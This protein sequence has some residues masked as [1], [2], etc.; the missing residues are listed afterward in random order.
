MVGEPVDMDTLTVDD[1]NLNPTKEAPAAVVVKEE[2]KPVT[3][4]NKDTPVV[5]DK[6]NGGATP[7]EQPIQQD[8]WTE[9]DDIDAFNTLSEETGIKIGGNTDIRD[10]LIELNKYRG[11]DIPGISPALKKAIEIEKQGGNLSAYFRTL[12]VEEDKWDDKEVLKHVYL[13]KSPVAKNNPRLAGMDFEREFRVRYDKFLTYQGMKDEAEKKEFYEQNSEDIEYQKER[14]S[15]DTSQARSEI[16]SMKD[17]FPVTVEQGLTQQQVDEI[18]QDHERK[19]GAAI[20]S[21]E[22]L[23]IPIEGEN[24]QPAEVFKIGLNATTK[25]VVEQWMRNPDQFLQAIGISGGVIDHKTLLNVA[26]LVA[27]VSEPGFGARFKKQI[28]DNKNI[29]TVETELAGARTVDRTLTG[30]GNK[31]LEQQIADKFEAKRAK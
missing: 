31:T 29:K 27:A 3:V 20:G 25:P 6:P 24:G 11:G 18:L 23:D 4:E 8:V 28:L 22:T 30:D 7:A 17:N 26:S 12:T 13:D 19:V 10:S 9:Q 15:F 1:V 16:K 5:D 14:Y 2:D 21:F